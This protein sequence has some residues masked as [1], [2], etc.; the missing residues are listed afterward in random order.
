MRSSSGAEDDC[1]HGSVIIE[2]NLSH[3]GDNWD[4]ELVIVAIAILVILLVA[5]NLSSKRK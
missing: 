4:M 1:I 2:L 3:L 5:K